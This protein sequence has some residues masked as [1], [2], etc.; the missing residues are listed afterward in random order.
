MHIS[1]LKISIIGCLESSDTME[2][3]QLLYRVQQALLYF[4]NVDSLKL[5]IL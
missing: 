4:L 3:T 1:V 2:N 5:V